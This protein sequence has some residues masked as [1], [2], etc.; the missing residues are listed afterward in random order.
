MLAVEEPRVPNW[1][2]WTICGFPPRRRNVAKNQSV[3]VLLEFSE[4]PVHAGQEPPPMRAV[5]HV[6]PAHGLGW[7]R[8][9]EVLG[10]RVHSPLRR[11]LEGP[12]GIQ[13]QF[14]NHEKPP[15]SRNPCVSLGAE[16]S[17]Q[18]LG[19]LQGKHP[20]RLL[21]SPEAHLWPIR[22]QALLEITSNNWMPSAL[23]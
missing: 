20:R 9:L 15:G 18:P 23:K 1:R 3:Q 13:G 6:V 17:S 22:F 19:M 7:H 8:G 5:P 12:L 21:H 2:V 14:S 16:K 11:R 10:R 4:Q